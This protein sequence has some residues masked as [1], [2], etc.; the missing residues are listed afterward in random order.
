MRHFRAKEQL[1]DGWS[2][3]HY[4][5]GYV[6]YARSVRI[7]PHWLWHCDSL[8]FSC[9]R[10]ASSA[11]YKTTR[12]RQLKPSSFWSW[13]RFLCKTRKNG[14][15]RISVER[16][17]LRRLLMDIVD[18]SPGSPGF[19]FL[20][21]LHFFFHFSRSQFGSTISFL[22][23]L[24][25]TESM[26]HRDCLL[27][28][29]LEGCGPCLGGLRAVVGCWGSFNWFFLVRNLWLVVEDHNLLFEGYRIV[30]SLFVASVGRLCPFDW[31]FGGP[32][33]KVCLFLAVVL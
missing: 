16:R 4:D 26:Q 29:L 14:T 5:L 15:T 27:F 23:F 32:K 22:S 12:S 10:R 28:S 2:L 9:L 6:S 19:S 20:V 11:P 1:A 25:S 30:T 13:I 33:G 18:G 7:V 24:S 8:V 17:Q 31:C 3:V 21:F